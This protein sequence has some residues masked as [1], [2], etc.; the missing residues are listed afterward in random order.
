MKPQYFTTQEAAEYTRVGNAS[1]VRAWV[2]RGILR[3][4]GRS[5]PKGSYLFLQAT[6]D[7]FVARCA[8]AGKAPDESAEDA[9]AD[10]PRAARGGAR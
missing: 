7:A 4:D 5:G 8:E 10:A 1:T 9:S 6:L 2:Q 3:P